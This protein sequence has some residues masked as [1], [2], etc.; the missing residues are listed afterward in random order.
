MNKTNKLVSIV[1]FGLGVIVFGERSYAEPTMDQ[2]V[3]FILDNIQSEC[4]TEMI[5]SRSVTNTHIS[6]DEGVMNASEKTT[7][8]KNAFPI[9]KSVLW[10]TKVKLSDLDPRLSFEIS[11]SQF[12][13]INGNS[14]A[15]LKLECITKD[16]ITRETTGKR[17]DGTEKHVTG[18]DSQSSITMGAFK[19]EEIS[20]ALS[21]LIKLHG[22]DEQLF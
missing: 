5:D 10:V 3:N 22:G 9:Y 8:I 18:T 12:T 19:I 11:D 21:H 15:Y 14:C 7:H 2:T 20:K 16:C 17:V 4:D 13:P 6:F 1:A